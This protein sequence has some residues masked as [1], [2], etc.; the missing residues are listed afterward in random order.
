[1]ELRNVVGV[2]N[3]CQCFLYV[4]TCVCC[5]GVCYRYMFAML[6]RDPADLVECLTPDF[7]GDIKY[8]SRVASSGWMSTYTIWRLCKTC[9]GRCGWA[10]ACVC[11]NLWVG[12]Y[13][14]LLS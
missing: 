14:P 8:V 7:R 12:E 5:V 6:C 1:M 2:A 11:L 10:G 9:S 13:V 4:Y 3:T